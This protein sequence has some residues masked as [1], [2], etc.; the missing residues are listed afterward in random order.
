MSSKIR[1]TLPHAFQLLT[2]DNIWFLDMSKTS[3]LKVPK[4]SNRAL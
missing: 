4:S 3:Y 2:L 1:S